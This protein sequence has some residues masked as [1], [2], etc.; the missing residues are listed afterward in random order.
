ML[1]FLV[2]FYLQ[3]LDLQAQIQ[4]FNLSIYFATLSSIYLPCGKFDISAL[5]VAF[6]MIF[7]HFL[8]V[9]STYRVRKDISSTECISIATGEYRCVASLRHNAKIE[10][11][12]FYTV[13]PE[14]SLTVY[15]P[16]YTKDLGKSVLKPGTSVSTRS[17]A[18][19]L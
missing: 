15:S 2:L 3:S 13:V 5:A 4:V 11:F 17:L 1:E 9:R 10:R 6:D 12:L 18:S 14:F 7:A 8:L 16:I 19:T